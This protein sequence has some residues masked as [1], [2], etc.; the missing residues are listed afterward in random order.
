MQT[1]EIAKELKKVGIKEDKAYYIAESINGK[2]GLATKEDIHDLDTNISEVKNELKEDI[3]HLDKKIDDV[4]SE[5]KE[6]IGK[7]ETSIKWLTILVVSLNIPILLI[8]IANALKIVI[9]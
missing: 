1:L 9:K 4:K 6:D 2:S 8:L 7:L 5:L 3:H